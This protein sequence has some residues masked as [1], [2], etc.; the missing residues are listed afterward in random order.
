MEIP[1]KYERL[2]DYRLTEYIK[3]YLVDLGL[4]KDDDMHYLP[5][6]VNVS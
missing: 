3:E 6:L 2:C 4:Q 1:K 5:K